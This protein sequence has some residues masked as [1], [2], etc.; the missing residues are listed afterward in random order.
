VQNT[1]E[2]Q[3]KV[4][5]VD[6]F[7]CFCYDIFLVINHGCVSFYGVVEICLVII[8]ELVYIGTIYVGYH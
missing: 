6:K 5:V 8:Y 4:L 3:E 2:S 1:Y 7:C